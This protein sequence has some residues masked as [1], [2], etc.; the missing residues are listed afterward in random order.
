MKDYFTQ[1]P[2]TNLL[3]EKL[4]SYRSY[5][6]HPITIFLHMLCIP[7]ILFGTFIILNWITIP[8]IGL[9]IAW[10]IAIGLLIYY[11]QF[12]QLLCYVTGVLFLILLFIVHSTP[13]RIMSA[14]SIQVSLYFFIGGWF[15][16]IISHWLEKEKPAFIDNHS[17]ILTAIIYFVA[18]L[19]FLCGVKK[20]LYALYQKHLKVL[21]EK[22]HAIQKA[23]EEAKKAAK[24]SSKKQS[25]K[26][27][28]KQEAKEEQAAQARLESS[29][30]DTGS[31]AKKA[32]Q[33]QD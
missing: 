27:K 2:K 12:D 7:A 5:H 16:Q 3:A 21:L 25:K 32:P 20:E 23:Q 22:K 4:A 33:K 1:K 13:L 29:T 31:S 28:K 30:K 9:S 10:P 11:W 18:E 17:Q 8:V 26:D 19:T 6:E 15:T 14:F 24:A